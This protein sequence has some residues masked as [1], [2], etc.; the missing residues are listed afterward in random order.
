MFWVYI[1]QNPAGRFYI[2]QTDD[3]DRRLREH[4]APQPGFGKYTH[5]NGPW[6]LAWKEPHGSRE[7]ALR[8]E[9]EIK[10]W[11]SSRLIRE[12]LLAESRP[13]RD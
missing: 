12:R 4:N 3:I 9:R 5:K 13:G 2:G 6:V 11:K 7:S 10:A 8:R 1:L